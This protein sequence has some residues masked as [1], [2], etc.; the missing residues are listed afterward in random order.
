MDSMNKLSAIRKSGGNNLTT[1]L[2]D[3]TIEAFFQRDPLL[4]QAIEEAYVR[5]LG[6][7][8][9]APELLKLDERL[10]RRLGKTKR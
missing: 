5:Y 3:A 10:L 6:I 2:P 9:E 7:E 8:S 4:V 1:G